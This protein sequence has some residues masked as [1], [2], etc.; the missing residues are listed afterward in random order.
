MILPCTTC[1]YRT[2]KSVGFRTFVGCSDKERK[3][4][5]FHEDD[6]FYHHSCDAY[7]KDEGDN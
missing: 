7:I 5:N 4:K 2:E 6:F 3:D 1:K